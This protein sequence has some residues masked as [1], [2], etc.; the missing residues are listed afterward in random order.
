[1]AGLLEPVAEVGVG[2]GG[3]EKDGAEGED[4]D[5]EHGTLLATECRMRA[6]SRREVRRSGKSIRTMLYLRLRPV[7]LRDE[8]EAADIGIS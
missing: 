1:M 8:W 2:D 6:A 4:D 3:D 5:I 7:G